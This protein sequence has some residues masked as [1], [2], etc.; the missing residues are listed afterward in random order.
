MTAALDDDLR[1]AI[2][3]DCAGLVNRYANLNDAGD[4]AGVAAL[5]DEHGMMARP[6]A[7]DAPIVGR[8]AILAA[9]QARPTRT[10]RHICANIV[11][12]V[13]SARTARGECAMLLFTDAA[14]PLIGSFHDRFVLTDEG[15]RF[16]ERRGSL[17]FQS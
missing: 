14:V 10:T 4:W 7:P 3:Q 8:A 1:R 5:Y 12:D 17:L 11:I 16:A 9:F 6:T 13:E 2:E 15:W